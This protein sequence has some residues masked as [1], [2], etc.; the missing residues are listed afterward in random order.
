M[1]F[2]RTGDVCQPDSGDSGAFNYHH[3]DSSRR[4]GDHRRTTAH[5]GRVRTALL[6]CP[7]QTNAEPGIVK[8]ICQAEGFRT[9]L[10]IH[11]G[12]EKWERNFRCF[13]DFQFLAVKSVRKASGINNNDTCTASFYVTISCFVAIWNSH[14]WSP[15]V[16]ALKNI[17]AAV[18]NKM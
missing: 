15:S 3:T 5:F 4:W 14:Q 11:S 18:K 1:F 6:P 13:L 2:P 9:C 10:G 8:D 12:E 17:A 7:A 16:Y